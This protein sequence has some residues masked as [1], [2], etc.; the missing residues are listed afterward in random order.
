MMFGAK[1]LSDFARIRR[2]VVACMRYAQRKRREASRYAMTREHRDDQTR[3]ESAAQKRAHGDIAGQMLAQ[4][5]QNFRLQRIGEVVFGPLQFW[6][7]VQVPITP[8]SGL[9]VPAHRESVTR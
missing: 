9:F 5:N 1:L 4:C 3:I 8:D 2:L 7:I 6:R